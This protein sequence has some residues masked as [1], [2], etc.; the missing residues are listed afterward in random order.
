MLLDDESPNVYVM[1]SMDVQAAIALHER[2]SRDDFKVMM[3]GATVN[4]LQDLLGTLPHVEDIQ[5][6]SFDQFKEFHKALFL[7]TPVN[8][9]EL[10]KHLRRRVME[11]RES[12]QAAFESFS[13]AVTVPDVTDS[14]LD[15]LKHTHSAV[16][17]ADVRWQT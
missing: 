11:K 6:F 12:L 7:M 2:K 16:V 10:G 13:T 9:A 1:A 4:A 17:K 14:L 8:I 15:V 5:R 3:K